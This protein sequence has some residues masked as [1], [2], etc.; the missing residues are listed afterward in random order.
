MYNLID[1]KVKGDNNKYYDCKTFI[2]MFAPFELFVLKKYKDLLVE[3]YKEH[4]LELPNIKNTI[5]ILK[6]LYQYQVYQ[7]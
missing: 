1:V 6:I 7:Y 4:K 2:S 5:P 3:G